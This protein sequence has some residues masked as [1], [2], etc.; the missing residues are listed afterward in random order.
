MKLYLILIAI[1]NAI[2][3]LLIIFLLKP[4]YEWYIIVLI[5]AGD[6]LIVFIIDLILAIVVN[7]FPVIVC[8]SI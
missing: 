5:T 4:A 7:K 3:D 6:T 1:F 2:I 8:D